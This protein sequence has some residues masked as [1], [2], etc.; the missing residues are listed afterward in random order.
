MMVTTI[1]QQQ[2]MAF[3]AMFFIVYR[4]MLTGL[5]QGLS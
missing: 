2:E 5:T 4:V 1:I 3:I